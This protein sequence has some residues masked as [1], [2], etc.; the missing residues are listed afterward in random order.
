MYCRP[1]NNFSDANNVKYLLYNQN[2]NEIDL[3]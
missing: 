1:G 2:E 3:F